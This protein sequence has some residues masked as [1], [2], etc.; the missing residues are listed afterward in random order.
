[1]AELPQL[2]RVFEDLEIDYCCGG[3][4][5][6]A[7]VCRERGIDPESLVETLTDIAAKSPQAD[8]STWNSAPLAAL[9]DDIQTTHHDYL[10]NEL[11]RLSALI[12]KVVKAHG[13]H[14]GELAAVEAT[15]SELRAEL[16]PHMMKEECILF[17]SIRYLENNG[18]AMQFPFGS[19]LN[20][21]RVMVS[22]HDH[23]GDAL[24]RIREL[25]RSYAVPPG[26][27]NTYRVM[28]ESLAELERDMH[29]HVHKENNIL[30]PR[31][32]ELEARLGG[33]SVVPNECGVHCSA[34]GAH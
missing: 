19:L 13:A 28:L 16:E 20:P 2:A 32:A 26:A 12:A 30:F 1:V 10:R 14:H 34:I 29:V 9:C 5:L 7:E 6:L 21:I 24:A 31:A 27:C 4:R 22:E 33:G 3:K 17:P 15:F 18:R 11:P 23:A 25:T 8:A